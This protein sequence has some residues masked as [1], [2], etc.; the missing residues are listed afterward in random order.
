M[1]RIIERSYSVKHASIA[2]V[3]LGVLCFL[4]LIHHVKKCLERWQWFRQKEVYGKRRGLHT[5]TRTR[6]ADGLTLQERTTKKSQTTS[7]RISTSQERRLIRYGRIWIK[8][9]NAEQINQ[10]NGRWIKR[11]HGIGWMPCRLR[12]EKSYQHS[13]RCSMTY[14]QNQKT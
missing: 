3:K 5:M 11:K 14:I 2:S 7:C 9:T 6:Y 12:H 4:D 1:E 13:G 8:E 10:V